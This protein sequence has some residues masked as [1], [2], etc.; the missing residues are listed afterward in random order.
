MGVR[1]A[2]RRGVAECGD[3]P[4]WRMHDATFRTRFRGPSR[5]RRFR[6]GGRETSPRARRRRRGRVVRARLA[7]HLPLGGP[8]PPRTGPAGAP[9]SVA[10]P[11][12]PPPCSSPPPAS[13]RDASARPP[14]SP[15]RPRRPPPP[16]RASRAP[17]RASR[18]PRPPSCPPRRA[19]RP[20]S[21]PNGSGSALPLRSAPPRVRP[22]ARP[23]ARPPARP[24]PALS[25]AGSG[26]RHADP[27]AQETSP[28]VI[29]SGRR[30]IS[31]AHVRR[32]PPPGS[33]TFVA[34]F[35]RARHAAR[36]GPSVHP[37][38]PQPE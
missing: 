13:A 26:P 25:G 1:A 12:T 30:R 11:R 16:P 7:R 32:V 14:A 28:I 27:P 22:L 5:R 18:I 35:R 21:P 9:P 8:R 10:L 34:R 31:L 3:I 2:P 20:P 36:P 15:P 38:R 23:F 37:F 33:V 19:P 17:P 24:P 6:R 4:P 29:V